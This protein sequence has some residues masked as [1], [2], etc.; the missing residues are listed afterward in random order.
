MTVSAEDVVLSESSQLLA[1]GAGGS[2]GDVNIDASES[3]T[4]MSGSVANVSGTTGGSIGYAAGVALELS[5][6]LLA[7]GGTGSGGIL[8]LHAPNVT[9]RAALLDASG[10]T[11]GS[12]QLTGG[13]I[14]VDGATNVVADGELGGGKV[15]AFADYG[16]EFHGNISARAAVE[17][18]LGGFAEVSGLKSLNYDGHADL[19]SPLGNAGTLILDPT[20][21]TIDAG[22]AAVIITNLL[23]SNV[24]IATANAGSGAGDIF[25]N[26]PVLYSAANSLSLLAHGHIDTNA[27]ILNQGNGALNLVAGWDG[28]TGLG[29]A[30]IDFA[31]FTST[32]SSFGNNGGSVFIGG[33]NNNAVAVGSR[34]G[35]TN[36]AGFGI[37]I[38]G[39]QSN[40]A[41]AQLGFP[42]PV[43]VGGTGASGS[44]QLELKG[45]LTVA[46]GNANFA[47]AQIGH[48]EPSTTANLQGSISINTLGNVRIIGGVNSS[49]A[50]IGH[51]GPSSTANLQGSISIN[52]PA[53]M[54]IIGGANSSYAQIGHGGDGSSGNQSGAIAV[55]THDLSLIGGNLPNA[56][57]QIGHGDA[58]GGASGTRIGA[59]DIRANG[60]TNLVNGTGN[61]AGWLIGH[62]T[63]TVSGVSG[64]DV[65]F[66]T[67]ALDYS[68]G[69]VAN[70]TTLNQDFVN[71]FSRNLLGGNVTIR[72]TGNGALFLDG[73]FNY[74]SSHGLTLMADG[75]AV[76]NKSMA[77]GGSGEIVLVI[78]AANSIMPNLS[79]AATLTIGSTVGLTSG[80]AI[81]IFAVNPA[82]TH[83]GGFTP[84]ERRYNVWFGDELAVAG[85]NYKFQ[86][87]LT[88]TPDSFTKAY[89]QTV[90][91]DGDEFTYSGLQP[92]DSLSQILSG[93]LGL[94]SPGSAAVAGVAGSPYPI[95]FDGGLTAGLGYALQL[96][97]GTLTVTPAPLSLRASDG[98]KVYGSTLTFAGTEFLASGLKNG[99]SVGLVD[100]ASAG[101]VATAGVTGSPYAITISNARGG[102]FDPAN[103]AL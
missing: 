95:T 90:M 18:G 32:P 24:V 97:S 37:A 78:D 19:R 9:T 42:A 38:I 26:A 53:N 56:Y 47:Y 55:Q 36:A 96:D 17:N 20:N 59:I 49:Y 13:D 4:G 22:V 69:T 15:V 81:R 63:S 46:G 65:L 88:L 75:G 89:G 28:V 54:R 58:A 66:S 83:L 16:M 43:P 61:N 99:E 5:G 21:F 33:G 25:V 102:S 57:A 68:L 67:T 93:N 8:E 1:T 29:G 77:N 11:G 3:I 34:A 85:V 86:P 30:G 14:V 12:V 50:Q 100:L 2:G 35:A 80:G 44:I 79:P 72:A 94:S 62:G 52:T 64:A 82:N 39:G 92:G 98:S 31:T 70:R 73:G 23:T 71:K 76:V 87:T 103:Y 41:F 91:F 74:D 10:G 6:R 84:A 51:G 27:S 40:S 101:A 48:G 45:D 7:R 60:E